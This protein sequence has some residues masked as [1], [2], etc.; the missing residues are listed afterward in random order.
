VLALLAC[1]AA[2][3]DDR[4]ATASAA[5]PA[6]AALCDAEM[7]PG[8]GPHFRFPPLTTDPHEDA[9]RPRWVHLWASWCKPCVEELPRI[10]RFEQ[11]LAA[12]GATGEV[13]LISA[14]VDQSRV[15]AFRKAHPDT[16][17]SYLAAHPGDLEGWMDDVGLRAGAGL[18]MHVF[19]GG[20]GHVRCTRAGPVQDAHFDAVAGLLK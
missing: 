15:D 18:P 2:C 11:R 17:D 12:M 3:D 4:D 14:D 10:A 1:T 5:T 20:D 9:A 6:L 7:A 19:V 13:V 16:P 8:K